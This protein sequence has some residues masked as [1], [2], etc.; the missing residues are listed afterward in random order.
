MSRPRP[1]SAVDR[2]VG[3]FLI[4]L[5]GI[6]SLTL[7]IGIPLGSLYVASKFT[8]NNGEHFIATLF[9]T[10]AGMALFAPALFWVNNLYLRVVGALDEEEDEEDAPPRRLRGPLEVFLGGSFVIAL[11]ALFVWFFLFAENPGPQ[12]I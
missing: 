11:V 2:V 6:G 12:V 8:D 7:W 5:L 1:R 9:M 4:A 10:L 3:A